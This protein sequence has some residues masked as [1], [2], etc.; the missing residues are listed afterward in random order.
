MH[1]IITD[2]GQMPNVVPNHSQAVFLVRA[3]DQA[4]LEDL[5]RRVVACFEAGAT[6]T[7]ARLECR[8]DSVEYAPLRANRT[9]ADVFRRNMAALGRS[10][11]EPAT[12]RSLGSTDVGN[13]SM[14]LPT[15]HPSIRV[16][17]REVNIHT[18]DFARLAGSE[19]GDKALI[20]AAKAMA[21]TA[22]DILVDAGLRE[23]MWEEF[24][25]RPAG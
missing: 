11:K 5:K 12:P 8:W 4:Y 22:V 13:V 2:G 6:A 25:S 20:D 14:L 19:E 16:A 10:S 24:L 7:G 9:M 18:A 15:I 23:R 17:P 3:E 21:M 1:G